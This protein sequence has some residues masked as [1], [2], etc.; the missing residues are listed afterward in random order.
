MNMRFLMML[1]TALL[2]GLAG[3]L[4]SRLLTPQKSS[5]D[6]YGILRANRI[7][8]V[9]DSGRTK[10]FIGTD[11]ERD[12]ALVF[13]DDQHRERAVF[14][15]GIGSYGPTLVMRGGD[16]EDRVIFR[17]SP[18]VDD[19]P[20]IFLRDHDTTRVSLGFDENDAPSPKDDLWALRFSPP[21]SDGQ[22]NWAGIGFNR[23]SGDKMEGFVFVKGKDGQK[24]YAPK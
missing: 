6:H 4:S 19:R 21:H 11:K 22:H 24:W 12:T 14:G 10:A 5:D 16:G 17:L 7:E 23:D 9:D 20:T 15:V 1:V 2:A 13:L 18:R 3:G 8:L